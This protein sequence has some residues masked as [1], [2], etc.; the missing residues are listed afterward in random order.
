MSFKHWIVLSLLAIFTGISGIS[1]LGQTETGRFSDNGKQVISDKQTGLSWQKGDSFAEIKKGMNWYEAVDYI[2]KKNKEKFGGY[3]DWRLPTLDE[4]KGIWDEKR[5]LRSKDGE[6]V[7]LPSLFSGG[8]SYYLWTANERNL[9]HAW[10]F[11]LG[12]KEEYFN[13]KELGDLE[14]GVKMVRDN[15]KVGKKP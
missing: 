1:T 13:L 6:P 15:K 4:F 2:N 11:G 12:Q 10:Y 5:P 8:G 7:G 9:D 14:Q 3:Q